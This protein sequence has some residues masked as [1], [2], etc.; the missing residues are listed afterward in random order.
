MAHEQ[1]MSIDDLLNGLAEAE[2][3]DS[4]ASVQALMYVDGVVAFF[5][6]LEHQMVPCVLCLIFNF[7]NYYSYSYYC[8]RLYSYCLSVLYLLLY[9]YYYCCTTVCAI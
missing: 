4:Q 7:R 1:D 8:C 5:F 9:S 6:D 3:K 2:G